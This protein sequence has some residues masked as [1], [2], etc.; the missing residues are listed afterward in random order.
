M[1]HDATRWI[2]DVADFDT[3]V[4]ESALVREVE[5]V[6]LEPSVH[7]PRHRGTREARVDRLSITNEILD[8][9]QH[10]EQRRLAAAA[11]T[12]EQ[13]D[14]LGPVLWQAETDQATMVADLD[15]VN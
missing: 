3:V 7:P 8:P 4:E 6:L 12:H 10:L 11:F 9:S 1:A 5:F 15:A 13:V 14:R 2:V